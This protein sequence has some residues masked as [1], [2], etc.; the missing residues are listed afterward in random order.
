MTNTSEE[1][2][3]KELIEKIK[4]ALNDGMMLGIF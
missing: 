4:N 1:E 3:K 2:K